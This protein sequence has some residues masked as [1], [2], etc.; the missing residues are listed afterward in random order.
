MA[1]TRRTPAHRGPNPI[2]HTSATGQTTY[3]VRYRI[4]RGGPKPVETSQ[5]FTSIQRASWFSGLLVQVRAAE[6]ERI[7]EAMLA[8]EAHGSE[9]ALLGDFLHSYIDELTGIEEETKRKYRRFTDRDIVPFFGH[10]LPVDGLT[11]AMDAAWVVHLEQ[12]IGNSAKTIHNKHGFLCAAMG[13][14][15]RR[16]PRPLIDYNPCA[17]TRLPQVYGATLDYFTDEEY[18]FFEQLLSPWWRPMFEF[19]TMS[20]ARPG[21]YGALRV[22]DVDP[23]TGAVNIER[24]W[25]WANG[26]MKMGKPKSARGVRTTYAPLETV[27]RLDLT[28]RPLDAF[29]FLTPTGKP[30]TAVRIYQQGWQPAMAR[31]HA[32]ANRDRTPFTGQAGWEGLPYEQLLD[33]FGYLLERMLL[34][35]LTPYSTRHTGIS[36]RLQDGEPIWVVSRDA[37]HESI[38]TTDK[39]YGHIS[40]AAS[41]AAARTISGRLPRLRARVVDLEQARRRRLVRLGH[42]GEICPVPGGGFEAIWMDAAGLVQSQVFPDYDAAVAHVATYEAGEPLAA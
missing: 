18:E 4:D 13:A 14:A 7:L 38:V 9:F 8:A 29:L 33:R 39:K 16:R 26:A 23:G 36:W 10:G 27:A 15:A 12:E 28:G 35:R 30:V 31:L 3:K 21:E 40:A 19:A 24:A 37:G 5:T 32:L 34:K 20:M 2:P 22:G 25:K 11:P 6:A 1:R 41:A 17:D 42:L